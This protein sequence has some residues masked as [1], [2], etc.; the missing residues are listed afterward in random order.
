V[1]EIDGRTPQD[2][3]PRTGFRRESESAPNELRL[4]IDPNQDD[5]LFAVYRDEAGILSIHLPDPAPNSPAIR[6]G[7]DPR[8]I[9]IKLRPEPPPAADSNRRGEL[10]VRKI[11]TLVVREAAKPL[12]GQVQF[13][14]VKLW[15]NKKR[16]F[17]GFHVG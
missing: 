11:I 8:R 6:R 15:E 4:D 5:V 16:P 1:L 9:R 13:Q 12:V 2:S 7:G 14:A 10:S 17:Q 3:L